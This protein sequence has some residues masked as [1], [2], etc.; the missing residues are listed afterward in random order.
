MV[1][2]L[3]LA[4]LIPFK[5]LVQMS[6]ILSTQK[7]RSFQPTSNFS[8]IGPEFEATVPDCL[9]PIEHGSLRMRLCSYCIGI[10][11]FM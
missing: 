3:V 4:S 9:S 10:C 1:T 6:N 7:G 11:K 5:F 8:G 2:Y